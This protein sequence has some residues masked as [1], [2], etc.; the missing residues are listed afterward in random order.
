ME[1]GN[2]WIE[3]SSMADVGAPAGLFCFLVGHKTILILIG[4]NMSKP[5]FEDA[6]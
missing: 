3:R 4:Q 6:M 5:F 2:S 1:T